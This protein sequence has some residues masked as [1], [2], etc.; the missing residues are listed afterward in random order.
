MSIDKAATAGDA[1]AQ[2]LRRKRI[3]FRAWH[4][5]MR[6]GDLLMGG[7]AERHL[8]GLSEAQV[9]RFEALLD[10]NDL[11]VY[12]WVT[13]RVPVPAAHD[14]DVMRMLQNFRYPNP[15][16]PSASAVATSGA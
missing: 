8:A 2:A 12:D 6:E 11:D 5:G 7:F 13:G 9:A 10:A 1:D 16:P 4:R 14:H 3:L 15:G